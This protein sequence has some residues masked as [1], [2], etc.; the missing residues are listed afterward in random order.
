MSTIIIFSGLFI[1][2]AAALDWEWFFTNWRAALF[3]RVFGRGGTR[4]FYGAL[5]AGVLILG[6][7]MSS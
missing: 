3:V 4:V 5:G 1:I 6:F 2:A 7:A